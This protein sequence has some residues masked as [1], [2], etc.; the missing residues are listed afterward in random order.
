MP[1]G[2]HTLFTP[3]TRLNSGSALIH[4]D[5][6]LRRLTI[7]GERSWCGKASTSEV[8]GCGSASPCPTVVEGTGGKSIT[9]AWRCWIGPFHSKVSSTYDVS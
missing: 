4:I 8:D 1:K 3:K 5:K 6:F 2:R 9:T 7:W